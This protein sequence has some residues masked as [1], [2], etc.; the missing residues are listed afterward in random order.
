MARYTDKDASTVRAKAFVSTTIPL[1]PRIVELGEFPEGDKTWRDILGRLKRAK[2]P[3]P[4][5]RAKNRAHLLSAKPWWLAVTIANDS[6]GET[7]RARSTSV[8]FNNRSA[9]ASKGTPIIRTWSETC[10]QPF[11]EHARRS[12]YPGSPNPD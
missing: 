3:Q 4:G 8:D 1:S 2:T 10:K 11:D 6:H 9:P 7:G 12:P 5:F